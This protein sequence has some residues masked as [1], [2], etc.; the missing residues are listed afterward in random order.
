[1]KKIAIISISAILMVSCGSKKGF[2]EVQNPFSGSK[3]ESNG[4]YFRATASGSSQNLETAK[5]KAMLTAKQRLASLVSTQMK[6]VSESYKG[7]RQ[8]DETIDGF[9]ERFQQLNREVLNQWLMEVGVIGEKTFV[10]A[11][12][13]YTCYVA[14]EMKKKTY[15]ERMKGYTALHKTLSDADKKHIQHM[16]DETLKNIKE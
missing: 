13:S 1:M 15:Y 11:N 9:N 10:N 4:S 6:S 16:L 7:E 5:D 2:N 8:A 14:L 12:K 3:Y